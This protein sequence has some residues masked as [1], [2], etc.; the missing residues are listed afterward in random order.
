MTYIS[1]RRTCPHCK[2][3]F[4]V[5]PSN[6]GECCDGCKEYYKDRNQITPE[7]NWTIQQH[8]NNIALFKSR[9]AN[10]VYSRLED[11]NY[12]RMEINKAEAAIEELKN[13]NK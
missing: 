7:Q 4:T 1:D 11:Q 5:H 12:M 13:A 6:G 8:L 10:P 3:G 9:L 2:N